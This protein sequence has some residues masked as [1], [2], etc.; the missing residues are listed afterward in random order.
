MRRTAVSVILAASACAASHSR[1]VLAAISCRSPFRSPDKRPA[2]G[3]GHTAM[4]GPFTRF[5]KAL[6]GLC[7]S[8]AEPAIFQRFSASLAALLPQRRL[9][10]DQSLGGGGA[11]TLRSPLCSGGETMPAAS[12]A[13]TRRAA[14]L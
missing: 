3:P 9:R 11:S 12:I 4:H 6:D 8:F 2:A 5:S 13:S 10:P 7:R 1:H 14:R